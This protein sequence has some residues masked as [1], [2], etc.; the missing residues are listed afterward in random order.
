MPALDSRT[1][2]A[3]KAREARD[4]LAAALLRLQS[5]SPPAA[6]LS[7][8]IAHAA[9]A[10][11][12]LYRAEAEATTEEASH[13]GIRI[14]VEELT[15]S[16]SRLSEL[17]AR[18]SDFEVPLTSLA[19]TLALLYPIARASLRQRRDV[20]FEGAMS[21]VP[22]APPRLGHPPRAQDSFSGQ[23]RRDRKD[24]RVFVE[25][26]IGLLSA[27]NFYTG[28]SLDVSSG[29][30]FVSTYQPSQPGTAISMYFVLPSGHSVEAEGIVRWTRAA[31][32]D[33]EPGMGI[34]FTNLSPADA[35][36]ISEFCRTRTPLYYED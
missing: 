32:E 12:A 10:S 4:F 24:T 17:R 8:A 3:R 19:K 31:S 33:C 2:A 34:A 18:R 27:S 35:E 9:N 21:S 7:A 25:V 13:S 29:G 23:E 28:I 30:L 1:S 6:E 11:S 15:Q 14:A 36:A 26:D 5:I 20:H 22:P 16:L